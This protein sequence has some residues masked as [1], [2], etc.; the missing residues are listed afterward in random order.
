M[1][2]TSSSAAAAQVLD[3]LRR[4]YVERL[5]GV[6]HLDRGGEHRGLVLREGQVA[7]AMSDVAGER[8]G[9]VLVRHGDV[10]QD[11][12]D[13]AEAAARSEGR[14]LGAI[15]VDTGIVGTDQLEHA[16][17]THVRTML[18]SA[19]DE[20]GGPPS[21]ETVEAAAEDAAGWL[22]VSRLSTGQ[23]LLDA[24]RRL[25]DPAVVREA[26]GDQDRKLVLITDPWFRAQPVTLTPTDG[27]VLSRVDGTLSTRELVGLIP[28]APRRGDGEEPARS[29]VHRGRRLRGPPSRGGD[30]VLPT[31]CRAG[32]H[33]AGHIDGSRP[34]SGS[35]A[36][37]PCDRTRAGR[38]PADRSGRP[39]ARSRRDQ[40]RPHRG[41][42]PQ[43]HS[44]DPRVSRP[45]GPFRGPG[46]HAGRPRRRAP[47]G[48]R[49][50][51]P[52]AAPGRVP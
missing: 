46:D 22:A 32:A 18:Y 34:R 43:P 19:L 50:A 33:A 23:L 41:R 21:F 37:R 30:G 10:T 27:F 2:E 12:F 8:L 52:H 39:S 14:R 49:P 40:G 48:L 26:L 36:R 6:L 29:A 47:G 16:V 42:G 15:L 51:R 20:P 45:A 35:S 5:S 9:D 24:V 28:L 25:E 3:L 11:V 17:A 44:R 7:Y 4:A 31:G 13:R 38:S 1:D